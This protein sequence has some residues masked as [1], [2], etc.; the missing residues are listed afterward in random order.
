[1]RPRDEE[2]AVPVTSAIEP[3]ILRCTEDPAHTPPLGAAFYGCPTYAE[4]GHYAP[5][6]VRYDYAA[7]ATILDNAFWHTPGASI[8]RRWIQLA[9]EGLCVEPASAVP[10]ARLNN[11]VASDQIGKDETVVSLL[12]ST[13]IKWPETLGMGLDQPETIP[14]TLGALDR[15]PAHLGLI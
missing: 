2:Y 6:E 7:L 9:H 3:T 8:W 5:L 1:M 13:G 12:T 14:G 15:Q 10:I 4:M 11:L